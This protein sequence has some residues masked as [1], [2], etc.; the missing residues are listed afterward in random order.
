MERWPRVGQSR[1][2]LWGPAAWVGCWCRKAPAAGGVW[3]MPHPPVSVYLAMQEPVARSGTCRLCF[4][5]LGEPRG[6]H[7]EH[8]FAS[9]EA[10][11]LARSPPLPLGLSKFPRSVLLQLQSYLF[12]SPSLSLSPCHVGLDVAGAGPAPA[13]SPRTVPVRLLQAA[14]PHQ[15]GR[16]AQPALPPVARCG[17]EAACDIESVDT[18]PEGGLETPRSSMAL[19]VLCLVLLARFLM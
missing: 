11:P 4:R 18:E 15:P 10:I 2:P 1:C 7:T 14:L 12:S 13:G 6:P 16:R 19:G 17:K 3:A 8:L 9:L 5:L